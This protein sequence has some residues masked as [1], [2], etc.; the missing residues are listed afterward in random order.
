VDWADRPGGPV[1]EE[2]E[3]SATT[4]APAPIGRSGARFARTVPERVDE[5]RPAAGSAPALPAA[6][7][8]GRTG[9]RF[10]HAAAAAAAAGPPAG[11]D[12]SFAVVLRGYDRGEVDAYVRS[13]D[14]QERRLRSA[15]GL[16]EQRRDEAVAHA[17]ATQVENDRLREAGQ[18]S[19]PDESSFG[20]RAERLLR[21]AESEAAD[22]R[23]QAARDAAELGERIQQAA[24][25]QRHAVEQSFVARAAELEDAAAR[26]AA[27]LQEREDELLLQLAA[28]RAE[29]D[30][31]NTAA[32]RDAD[33][34]RR[35]AEAAAEA[36]RARLEDDLRRSRQEAE[37]DLE[38]LQRL[39]E[40]ARAA[41]RRLADLVTAQLAASRMAGSG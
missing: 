34:L 22:I 23:A 6:P 4:P 35:E 5:P 9:A 36:A 26:R 28:I 27:A 16:A 21:L 14:A 7:S 15:L 3:M 10:H 19:R 13:R 18:P 33:R 12:L 32:L 20:P 2:Q 40:E 31:V 29:A 11:V 41:L 39:R 30:R 24:E 37:G 38:R 8:V 1:H 25:A 17:E